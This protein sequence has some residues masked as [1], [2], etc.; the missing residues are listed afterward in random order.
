[1]AHAYTP[2]LRVT[3]HARIDKDRRLLAGPF[4]DLRSPDI[5]KKEIAV[6]VDR[7]TLGKLESLRQDADSRGHVILGPE[8]WSA[9]QNKKNY[10]CIYPS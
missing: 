2:G 1:M 8:V 9:S 7:G 3:G 10:C 5:G 4:V 6:A